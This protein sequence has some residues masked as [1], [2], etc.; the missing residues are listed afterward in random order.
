MSALHPSSCS[1]QTLEPFLTLLFLTPH[2]HTISE[3]RG[4]HCSPRLHPHPGLCHLP[5]PPPCRDGRL[6]GLRAPPLFPAVCAPRGSRG[7]PANLQVS[8]CSKPSR[9]S[10]SLL[11]NAKVPPGPSETR[12]ASASRLLPTPPFLICGALATLDP[13]SSL[14]TPAVGPPQCLCACCS[15]CLESCPPDSRVI[16]SVSQGF[17]QV[18]P[19]R[20]LHAPP[21]PHY[22][23]TLCL[24]PSRPQSDPPS[25][26]FL[27]VPVGSIRHTVHFT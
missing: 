13:P 25:P 14:K 7:S 17:S 20:G 27:T 15:L 5:R 16:A 11:I 1:G 9:G 6:T 2:T 4:D 24:L 19:Q 8:T 18:S 26:I 21:P 12:P 10:R 22:P 23:V 3:S